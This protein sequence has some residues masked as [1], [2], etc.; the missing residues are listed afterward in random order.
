MGKSIRQGH[1]SQHGIYKARFSR[2]RSVLMSFPGDW[3]FYCGLLIKKGINVRSQCRGKR[4]KEKAKKKVLCEIS[5]TGSL[6]VQQ[7]SNA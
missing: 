5:P 4:I 1:S 7:Q 6:R 2:R 3:I